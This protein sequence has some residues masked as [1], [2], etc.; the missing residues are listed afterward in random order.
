MS[1]FREQQLYIV[2]RRFGRGEPPLPLLTFGAKT[3]KHCPVP[4]Y[5]VSGSFGNIPVRI[6]VVLK[7][8]VSHRAAAG[9]VKVIVEICLDFIAIG[10]GDTDMCDLA[11]VREIIKIAVYS[12]AADLTVSTSD[13]YKYLIRARMIRMSADS[14]KNQFALACVSVL[15]HCHY[16]N[17]QCKYSKNYIII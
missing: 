12:P 7:R 13:L 1:C 6:M 11:C 17:F 3:L 4:E 5:C 9:A 14:I 8:H 2:E 16:L 10:T 15:L